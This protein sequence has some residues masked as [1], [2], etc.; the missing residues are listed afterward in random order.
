MFYKFH[1]CCSA[2]S[3]SKC[4]KRNIPI[5]NTTCNPAGLWVLHTTKGSGVQAGRVEAE[6][7]GA[8]LVLET[9]P[10]VGLA[11]LHIC[12]CAYAIL[13]FAQSSCLH[14]TCVDV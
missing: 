9:Y 11:A 7:E 10:E 5:S 4:F 13:E 12:T 14:L 2:V 3:N 6:V 1:I 8:M